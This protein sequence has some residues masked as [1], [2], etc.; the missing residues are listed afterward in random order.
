LIDSLGGNSKTLMLACVNS[1]PLYAAESIRTL[2]FAMGV[3]KIKNKPTALLNPHEKL[4]SDLK[5]QIRLLTLE[6]MMLRSRAAA[7][8]HIFSIEEMDNY[9]QDEREE[10]E[11]DQLQVEKQILQ[12]T[13]TPY[14][15]VSSSVSMSNQSSIKPKRKKKVFGS[16]PKVTT[17]TP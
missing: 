11:K 5:E 17:S 12:N 3:A 1:S 14:G 8:E 9:I 10:K 16:K 4:I 2:E 13:T 15:A 7:G 6:N